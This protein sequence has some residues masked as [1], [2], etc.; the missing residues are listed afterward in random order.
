MSLCAD[1]QSLSVS[2]DRWSLEP[3][4]LR[5]KWPICKASS[6]HSMQLFFQNS[7]T[8]CADTLGVVLWIQSWSCSPFV[9][10]NG[11]LSYA[12][13]VL[14]HWTA[15]CSLIILFMR[16]WGT[17]LWQNWRKVYNNYP[18]SLH[19]LLVTSSRSL[20][21][22]GENVKNS[23]CLSKAFALLTFPF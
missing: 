1:L 9:W 3:H 23:S 22:D 5:E 19:F 2:E 20:K 8:I 11:T 10:Q 17:N 14:W 4:F 15:G 12:R 16:F 13:E 7:F 18:E 6:G 21:G